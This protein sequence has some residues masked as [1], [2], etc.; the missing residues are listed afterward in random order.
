MMFRTTAS[1]NTGKKNHRRMVSSERK[2]SR[3]K[4]GMHTNISSRMKQI[5]SA[6]GINSFNAHQEA[7]ENYINGN[8]FIANP[9]M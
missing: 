2:S 1:N 7:N 3:N 5:N 6:K 9:Q 8:F 4:K